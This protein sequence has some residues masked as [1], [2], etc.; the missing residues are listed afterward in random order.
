M[1]APATWTDETLMA[2]ADGELGPAEAASVAAAAAA[3]P[4]L[5][6]RIEGFRQSR[7]RIAVLRRDTSVPDALVARIRALDSAS[8]PSA[9][10]QVMAF[11]P[12]PRAPLWQLPLAACVALLAGLAI[13]AFLPRTDDGAATGPALLALSGLDEALP[14]LPSGQSATLAGGARLTAISTFE[15]ETGDLCREIEIAA[16]EGATTAAIAC[17]APAGWETRL[18]L[19]ADG[20]AG[21]YAPAGALDTLDAWLAANG[22]GTPLSP[23]DEAARLAAD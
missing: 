13:G 14:A 2:F 19:A 15:T 7:A 4:A 21:G 20:G 22:A 18:A 12:R 10:A 17:R 5:A 8:A 3:D 1:T 11:T 6:A 23:Q 16:P 9:A